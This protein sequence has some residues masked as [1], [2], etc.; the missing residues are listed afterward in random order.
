[1]A[2]GA[3]L[4]AGENHY[5]GENLPPELKTVNG[6]IGASTGLLLAM[7]SPEARIAALTGIPLKQL[8][9]FLTGQA[10][11]FRRQQQDLVDTNLQTARI[12]QDTSKVER[13]NSRSRNTVAL[14]FLLPAV[15]G[16]GALAYY[17]HNHRKQPTVPNKYKTTGERGT[18]LKHQKIRIDVPPSALPPEFF[19]SLMKAE[20]DDRSHLQVMERTEPGEG[21]TGET[22]SE[23]KAASSKSAANVGAGLGNNIPGTAL[24]LPVGPQET[25]G[26]ALHNSLAGEAAE[27][28]PNIGE[29]VWN[30]RPSKVVRGLGNFVAE[31]TGVPSAVRAAKDL[32]SAAGAAADG[33]SRGVASRY[34]VGA[35]GN[36]LLA[37]PNLNWGL[38]PLAGKAIGATRLQRA[39]IPGT[40]R[41]K[42]ITNTP[43]LSQWMLDNMH[44][45]RGL[46]AVEKQMLKN[47]ATRKQT[48]EALYNSSPYSP[49][50]LRASVT[51]GGSLSAKGL[52]GNAE[53]VN[54][55]RDLKH[56]YIPH[57]FVAGKIPTTL[58]GEAVLAARRVGH[59]GVEGTRW[60]AA[61]ARR[62]PNMTMSLAGAPLANYGNARDTVQREAMDAAMKADLE[63]G[64]GT[65][66]PVSS[67]LQ[68]LLY[69]ATTPGHAAITS[70]LAPR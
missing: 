58:P 41:E 11:R 52:G 70:Q 5:L 10:D 23:S 24:S 17:A 56:P 55:M 28:V 14:S 37:I 38:A 54:T 45:A 46:T 16:G 48:F 8:A 39:I 44:G 53:L 62:W 68:Q 20:G 40:L 1:M 50:G 69:G 33:A 26:V 6:V 25:L 51:S 3:A 19:N 31:F 42:F 34:A 13:G 65:N 15:L 7:K 35:A 43:H 2:G 59:A 29:R 49:L 60:T 63:T 18:P 66:L 64:G 57:K 27:A 61:L 36:A 22:I 4:A 32:G 9:L 12:N 30:S 21:D 47:P 67:N